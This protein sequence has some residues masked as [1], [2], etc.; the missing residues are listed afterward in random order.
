M[1]F[2]AVVLDV[3]KA[4]HDGRLVGLLEVLRE[5]R[6]VFALKEWLFPLGHEF[7]HLLDVVLHFLDEVINLLHDA[8]ALLDEVIDSLRV[9]AKVVNTWLE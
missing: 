3:F 2:F 6:L 8:H 9:P 1:N 5:E 4:G 7:L